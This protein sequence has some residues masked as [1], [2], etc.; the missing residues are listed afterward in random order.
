MLRD[1]DFVELE[2]SKF[3]YYVA[4]NNERNLKAASEELQLRTK[5]NGKNERRTREWKTGTMQGE[6]I[7][8]SIPER[9]RVNARSKRGGER[10]S[11]W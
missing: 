4:D 7:A 9:N 11:D 10:G 8:W 6:S 5:I 1:Q 2:R 3:F